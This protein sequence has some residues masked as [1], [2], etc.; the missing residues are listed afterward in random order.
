MELLR[1]AVSSCLLGIDST[2]KQDSNADFSHQFL[3]LQEF[4]VSRGKKIVVIPIC[5]ESL[6][7]GV[8]RTPIELENG[9]AA[10]VLS[11]RGRVFNMVGSDVTAPF[12]RT[13]IRLVKVLEADV[14]V[15]KDGS[16]S[17]GVSEVYDGTFSGKKIRGRGLFA[18][19]LVKK[20]VKIFSERDSWFGWIKEWID[21]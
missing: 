13:C 12:L 4:S 16:P 1:V 2:Y 3:K 11:G 14:A 18:E 5:P 10:A 19:L 17:C 15:L 9:N 8:P 20:G 21:R 7:F 6:C